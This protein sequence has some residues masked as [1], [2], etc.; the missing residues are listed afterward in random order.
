V[1]RYLYHRRVLLE[2][3][4]IYDFEKSLMQRQKYNVEYRNQC[5]GIGLLY[6]AY[7]TSGGDSDREFQ[8]RISLRNIGDFLNVRTR[9]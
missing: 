4:G 7:K 3:E 2:F 5:A 6:S 1:V 9:R 8:L